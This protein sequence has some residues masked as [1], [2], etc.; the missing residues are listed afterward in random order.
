MC[1]CL[2]FGVWYSGAFHKIQNTK[3]QTLFAMQANILVVDDTPNNLRLL[4]GMLQEQGYTMRAAEDG[5]Y[6]LET[7]R[8]ELP[9]LILLDILMP[10]MSGY[11]VCQHLKADERTRD[12]PIIFISGLHETVDKVRAFASGA[13]D[14]I[15]KPFQPQEVLARVETH[16]SLRTLQYNLQQEIVRRKQSEDELRVRNAQ[17]QE[18]NASKNK[19]FSI[20]AHDLRGPI[21]TFRDLAEVIIENIDTYTKDALINILQTER[22]SANRLSILLDNLLNWAR[23]QQHTI[24]Y[25]PQVVGLDK[26]IHRN[27]E[28]V[29]LNAQKKRIVLNNEVPQ[30]IYVNVDFQMTNTIMLNVL[31]NALKFTKAEGRIDISAV[32]NGQFV[33]VVIADTGIGIP[34]KYLPQLFR[35]DTTYHQRGTADEPSTGLGLLLCKEFVEHHG[36]KIWIESDVNIGTTVRFTLPKSPDPRPTQPCL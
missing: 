2:V 30:G 25:L 9:D 20:L 7:I 32:P 24:E 22:E 4:M 5:Q 36:G 17:L 16:L 33:E 26:L 11:D 19:F 1:K 23:S 21:G 28:L 27:L 14:Y 35:L 13:V 29:S 10:K 18:A 8:A 6:A 34:A 31:S 15:T 3:L 12:I